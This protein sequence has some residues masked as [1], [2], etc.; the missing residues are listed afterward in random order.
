MVDF[1]KGIYDKE[2]KYVDKEGVEQVIVLK[3]LPARKLPTLFGVIQVFQ[4]NKS[5]NPEDFVKLLTPEVIEKLVDLCEE[6][7]KKSYPTQSEEERDGFVSSQFFKLFPTVIELNT[8][9]V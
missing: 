1:K 5:D 9:A 4:E 2:F 8:P 7:M 3:P 6:T